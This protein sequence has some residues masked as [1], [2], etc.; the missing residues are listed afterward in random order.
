MPPFLFKPHP[1]LQSFG[2]ITFTMHSHQIS[3]AAADPGMPA[4]FPIMHCIIRRARSDSSTYC[5]VRLRNPPF[6]RRLAKRRSHAR[7]HRLA[8]KPGE[9][10]GLMFRIG[11]QQSLG[12]AAFT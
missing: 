6:A 7:L 2:N 10:C 9:K 11:F 8:T 1:F 12:H 3:A 5:R 4:V